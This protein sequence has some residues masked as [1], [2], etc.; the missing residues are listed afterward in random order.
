[1]GLVS[2][3]EN[4]M[5]DIAAEGSDISKAT[6]TSLTCQGEGCSVFMEENSYWLAQGFLQTIRPGYIKESFLLTCLYISEVVADDATGQPC[7]LDPGVSIIKLA[8]F[9]IIN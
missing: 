6:E 5:L 9:F 8:R 1:M 7:G 4:F 3:S 2:A